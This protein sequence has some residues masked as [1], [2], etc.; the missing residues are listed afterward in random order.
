M[1]T[2][3]Y[4]RVS[5]KDKGQTV[6][7]QLNALKPFI[8][9]RGW[10][11][12]KIY[13]DTISGTKDSRPE[14]DKLMAD[15]RSRKIDCVCVWKFDRF[16]R[17]VA[18]L[19]RA[20]TEFRALGVQF[21]SLTEQFDTSTPMGNAMFNILATMSQLERELIAER[22]KTKVHQIIASGKTWGAP[23]KVF[24]RD[25]A[26]AELNAGESLR[27]VAKRHGISH[28]TLAREKARA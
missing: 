25:K 9:A 28:M 11:L 21:V 12:V 20:M 27:V 19:I 16:A 15:A 14:L 10:D 22:V 2:A 13:S 26:L 5:T 8:L 4:A 17:S 6:D 3:I 1:K 7:M 23:K 18:H 24:A